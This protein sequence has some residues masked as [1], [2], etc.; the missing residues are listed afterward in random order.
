MT[1]THLTKKLAFFLLFTIF[2]IGCV[3]KQGGTKI[4]T[5]EELRKGTDSL[6]MTFLNNMPPAKIFSAERD[7]PDSG[8]FEVGLKMENKG[9]ADVI[10]GIIALSLETG[11]VNDLKNKWK[12]SDERFNERNSENSVT[13]QVEGKKPENPTGDRL[14]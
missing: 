8:L 7:F 10:S 11:Y 3:P 2:L 5:E 12:S 1:Q 13:F 4:V 6:S 14:T 9:A